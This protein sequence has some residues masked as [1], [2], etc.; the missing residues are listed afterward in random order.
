MPVRL[1]GTSPG[2]SGKVVFLDQDKGEGNKLQM[3]YMVGAALEA[4][5]L[6]GA[7]DAPPLCSRGRGAG[8]HRARVLTPVMLCQRGCGGRL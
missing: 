7:A 6:H 2:S 4:R 5:P 3:Q 1:D 8:S